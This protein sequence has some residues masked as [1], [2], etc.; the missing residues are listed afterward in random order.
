MLR[1]IKAMHG[2]TRKV[3]L[4]PKWIAHQPITPQFE[5]AL[6][7]YDIRQQTVTTV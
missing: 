6:I 4:P 7:R 2:A 5:D 3:L 1:E